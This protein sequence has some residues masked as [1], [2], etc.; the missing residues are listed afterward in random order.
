[1]MEV[2]DIL[3]K[4]SEMADE[5]I[6]ESI[7]D[8]TPETLLRASEHLITAGGKKIRPSLALL[9][10]EAVGGDPG[11]AAGVAAAIELIH[12]FSL[13]HDDIMDDDEIRRGEPAVHVLWGEPMAILAGDVLFSKAFEA[14][15]RNGDSEMV[16]EALAVVVDSCVEICEGQALDMGFEERLDV[17]EEE[18]MEMIYKKTA[19]LI[20]AATKAG[21]IMGGGSPQEIAALED[22]GRCI[23]LAFQIHDDYLDVVSDEESLGKPVGSDIAEGKMTLMV[24]KALERASEKDRERLI[25]ILGSG[26]E[27]LVAEAIEI[28]ERYGATEYAHAVA[29][30]HVRMAKERLEVLEESDAREALAMIADFVLEREH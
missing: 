24:V 25:S 26:D 21:A 15:I 10:S 20:A 23:G 29:L 16:K 3:R 22:Y 11:D 17:T 6:R 13:I 19:A 4:Y 5:R 1:M 27:K 30:D 18:Y 2:M 7:S 14:V 12:T 8:I 9:S 28:F